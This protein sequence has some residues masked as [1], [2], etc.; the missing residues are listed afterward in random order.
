MDFNTE[1]NL[2][3]IFKALSQHKI[4]VNMMQNSAVS[5]SISFNYHENKFNALLKEL[6]DKFKIRYNIGLQLLTIRHYSDEILNKQLQG[7]NIFLEQKSR[8]TVQ[9][10][11]R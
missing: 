3:L 1:E 2:T 7:K 4:H 8:S 6:D 9:L 5:F 11:I 10:L